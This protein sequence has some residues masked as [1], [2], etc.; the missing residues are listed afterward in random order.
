MFCAEEMF[1]AVQMYTIQFM[2]GVVG[3]NINWNGN[4]KSEHVWMQRQFV[5]CGVGGAKKNKNN[6][7]EMHVSH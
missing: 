7:V 1:E 4:N 2:K 6:I 5:F 3:K